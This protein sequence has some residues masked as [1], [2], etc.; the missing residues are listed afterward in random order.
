MES[1]ATRFFSRV[2]EQPCSLILEKLWREN[3]YF[4][5]FLNPESQ[6]LRNLLAFDLIPPGIYREDLVIPTQNWWEKVFSHPAFRDLTI[7]EFF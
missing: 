2:M 3:K 7:Q 5:D 4:D 1:E 6:W